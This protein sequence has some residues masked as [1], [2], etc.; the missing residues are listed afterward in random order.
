MDELHVA[1]ELTAE[2]LS[3]VDGR[4]VWRPV[5]GVDAEWLAGQDLPESGR[6]LADLLADIR[7]RMLPYPMGNGHPRFFGWVNSAPSPA[8]VLVEPLAAALNPSCAGGDHAGVLLERAVVRWLA[9]LVGYPHRPGGGLLT[10]GASLATVTCLAAA[11]QRAARADGWDVR[12]DGLAGRPPFTGYVSAE[13]HGC[14]RR[15]AELLGIGSAWVRTIPVDDR[16]RMSAPELRSAI[17]ADLSAGARPLFVAANA[18]TVN[19]GAV[20]P[21]DELAGIAAE[22]GLWF[23]VDG[24]YGALG[25]LAPSAA[26]EFMGLELADSLALDPHKWLG[27]PVDCGCALFADPSCARDAF[28][29]VPAYLR[30]EESGELGWFAEYGP[31]QTRPFRALRTWAT[32][33]H[34]GRAGIVRLVTRTTEL[35]RTL[36]AMISE[37]RDFELLTPVVTSIVAF[38]YRPLGRPHEL[39]ELNRAIPAVVRQGGRAFLTGTRLGEA[40]ALR[41]CVLNPSTTEKDLAGLLGEIRLAARRFRSAAPPGHPTKGS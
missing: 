5:P 2:Y 9:G 13:G 25:V 30:D 10:S 15:A 24:A 27:V 26:P 4:P 8:G 33:S 29:L 41:A 6:P 1:A 7:D 3:R 32:M 12:T 19:T 22:H 16:F 38:R 28:S 36:A 21:L 23:H 31:E 40:E 34:L 37:E 39:D 14:L 11:R 18:G 20:D 17:E 35:A